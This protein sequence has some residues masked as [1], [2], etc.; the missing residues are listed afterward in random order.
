MHVFDNFFGSR[1][2]VIALEQMQS[3]GRMPQTI[4][5][6]GPEGVGK[7]TL[8]RRVAARLLGRAELIEQDDLSLEHN[9]QVIADDPAS[10]CGL[11]PATPPSDLNSLRSRVLARSFGPWNNRRNAPRLSTV[12]V[13]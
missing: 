12:V 9:R 8:A 3:S 13:Q 6:D 10:Q 2:A 1:D 5:L 4:L 7:A 11:T